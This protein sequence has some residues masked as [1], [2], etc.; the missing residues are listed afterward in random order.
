MLEK[1]NNINY[2]IIIPHKNIPKLLNRCLKSIPCRDDLEIII[3]DDNSSPDIVD[4]N[5]FP[6]QSRQNTKIIFNKNPKGA[7]YARNLALPYVRGKW[8][9]FADADDFFNPIFNDKLDLY[10]DSAY[11][12]IIFSANSVDSDTYE[13]VSRVKFLTTAFDKYEEDKKKG[14]ILLKYYCGVPWA[15]FIKNDLID[16][17]NI[18]FDEVPMHN[19][20]HFAY[21]VSY[22]STKFQ[23]DRTAIYC[24]TDRKSSV[25]KNISQE[26]LLARIYVI[27]AMNKFYKEHNIPINIDNLHLIQLTKLFFCDKNGYK[28][29]RSILKE[30]GYKASYLNISMFKIILKSLFRKLLFVKIIKR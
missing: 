4:F 25:S 19:D 10:K 28:K 9:I 12:F 30:M 21:L 3:V 16:K 22:H 26:A 29:G 14:E 18:L 2:T 24:V 6:G 13:N 1:S 20:M 15:K 23:V 11:D 27:G 5:N 8:V 17:N 7:G